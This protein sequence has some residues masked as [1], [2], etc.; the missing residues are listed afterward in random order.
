MFDSI[1]VSNGRIVLSKN[2]RNFIDNAKIFGY[3]KIA[4]IRPLVGVL[5]LKTMQVLFHE[6]NR[7]IQTDI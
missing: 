2:F 7:R 1:Y 6:R 4:S 3:N 5:R